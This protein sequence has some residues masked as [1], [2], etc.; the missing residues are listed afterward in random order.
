M[1]GRQ[2][3]CP[4]HTLFQKPIKQIIQFVKLRRSIWNT[5][6]PFA[7]YW[8]HIQWTGKLELFPWLQGVFGSSRIR[9]LKRFWPKVFHSHQEYTFLF[10]SYYIKMI[11]TDNALKRDWITN[12]L[13][14]LE[15][16]SHEKRFQ[17]EIWLWNA[18]LPVVKRLMNELRRKQ[19]ISIKLPLQA[20]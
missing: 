5:E 8:I 10:Q 4:R 19:I 3:T 15:S 14:Q 1:G 13:I 17:F 18:L 20:N 7:N 16:V 12:S 6:R 9:N 2:T 11:W